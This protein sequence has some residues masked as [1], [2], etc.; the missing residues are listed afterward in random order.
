MGHD[1][2]SLAQKSG[3]ELCWAPDEGGTDVTVLPSLEP[4]SE[5]ASVEGDGE[6]AVPAENDGTP[7]SI[8]D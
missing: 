2:E 6:P 7:R 5:V 8:P 4:P 1:R 3:D